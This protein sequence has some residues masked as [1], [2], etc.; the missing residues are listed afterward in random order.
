[1]REV[2]SAIMRYV[3]IDNMDNLETFRIDNLAGFDGL[4][5]SYDASE[6]QLYRLDFVRE[7][8]VLND[9]L[10]V[11]NIEHEYIVNVY[12]LNDIELFLVGGI[13]IQG[14]KYY[15]DQDIIALYN[16]VF[17]GR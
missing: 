5:S 16:N 8:G 1:M 7:S 11:R 12:N 3:V 4:V 14:Q 10:E 6:Q 9:L 13:E 2:R 17:A 15:K